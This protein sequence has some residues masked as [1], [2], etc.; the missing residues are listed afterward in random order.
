MS[1]TKH[2]R[3]QIRRGDEDQWSD[4]DQ[5]PVLGEGEPSVVLG[6]DLHGKMKIGDGVRTWNQ[7]CFTDADKLSRVALYDGSLEGDGTARYPLRVKAISSVETLSHD[8]LIRRMTMDEEEV[9][10]LQPGN[11]Y[12]I[13]DFRTVWEEENNPSSHK[14]DEESLIVLATSERT[15]SPKAFSPDYPHD[16]IWYDAERNSGKYEWSTE[17][18]CGQIYRRITP[19]GN[20]VPYDVR[21]IR[22]DGRYTFVNESGDNIVDTP[23]VY[24]N[25]IAPYY[26]NG[27]QALNASV[28]VGL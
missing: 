12:L 25:K 7:L 4:P 15:L 2:V 9:P 6:G 21:A 20:D 14:G 18:D 13:S 17:R 19:N 11:F 26:V 10:Q 16:E 27:V 22:F 1:E 3:I 28:F 5:N 24:G 23:G 8:A